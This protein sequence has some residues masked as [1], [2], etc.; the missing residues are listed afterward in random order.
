MNISKFNKYIKL[1][2]LSQEVLDNIEDYDTVTVTGNINCCQQNCTDLVST[3]DLALDDT[4]WQ[5]DLDSAVKLNNT[6]YELNIKS[7]FSLI[8]YNAI[9]GPIDLSYV[10]DNCSSSPCTLQT[11]SGHFAPLFKA[12][13]ENWFTSIGETVTATV[14]FSGNT[15]IVSGIPSKFTLSTIGYGLSED[16]L[17][18][19]TFGF[20]DPLNKIFI[21]DDSIYINPEFFNDNIAF[22][23]GVYSFSIK[24][25]KEDSSGWVEESNC[26][27]VDIDNDIKCK[28][29]SVLQNI[30]KESQKLDPEQCSGIIH[31][32]HYALVNGSNCGCNCTE[33]CTVYKEL[34]D[35]LNTIDP[36]I[37]NNC[38]C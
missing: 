11:F 17:T 18:F 28:V 23:S 8:D 3:Y 38:G 7:I 20:T 9:T 19:T 16:S 5:I 36:Q 32:L 2:D 34:V 14:T 12:A 10:E 27:F 25:T 21:S 29:A 26:A 35:L 13:I 24:W 33:L 15:V 1:S 4:T 37:V 30:L 22:I 31:L 6:V